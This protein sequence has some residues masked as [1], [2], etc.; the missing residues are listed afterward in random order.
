M[1]EEMETMK[2]E[3]YGLQNQTEEHQQHLHTELHNLR[4]EVKEKLDLIDVLEGE[5]RELEM[6]AKKAEDEARETM[7]ELQAIQEQNEEQ[8]DKF[9]DQ[10][11]I[12]QMHEDMR[13]LLEFK[14]ELEALIEEQNKDIEEK[15]AK[16][17]KLVSE[18]KAYKTEVES[19]DSYIK[20]LEK[21][22][23]EFKNKHASAS[24]KLNRLKQGKVTELQK[25]IK[26]L[27]SE[28][29]LLKDMVKSSKNE[30]R[31]KEISIKQYKKRMT[32]LEKINKI[33]SKVSEMNSMVSQ[34]SQRNRSMGRQNETYE[35]DE[36]YDEAYEDQDEVI[37]EAEE[38]L[39]ATGNQDPYYNYSQNQ[40]QMQYSKTPNIK[41][42]KNLNNSKIASL[43]K[44]SP[45]KLN[46]NASMPKVD[47]RD[48]FSKKVSKGYDMYKECLTKP[49]FKN[50]SYGVRSVFTQQNEQFELPAIKESHGAVIFDRKRLD[51]LKKETDD[52]KSTSNISNTY[53]QSY[54]IA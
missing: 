7:M 34:N 23:K 46:P 26:D 12:A 8:N 1:Q 11:D 14:N 44:I 17:S 49:D 20:N 21:Q 40:K 28:V 19:K 33:R 43:S 24:T 47:G 10:E 13:R 48:P 41:V 9:G 42:T 3:L 30:I 36:P 4:M 39:E 2:G 6:R 16:I 5:N 38:N 35:Y 54:R 50:N 53:K 29:N 25:K 27:T 52:T 18:L 15:T 32:S 51:L 37:V 22:A 31:A 45:E